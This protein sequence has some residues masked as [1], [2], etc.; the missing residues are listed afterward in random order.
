[1]KILIQDGMRK[2]NRMVAVKWCL[3][4]RRSCCCSLSL[5]FSVTRASEYVARPAGWE[6]R[7]LGPWLGGKMSCEGTDTSTG[8]HTFCY[9]VSSSVCHC[10]Y[11]SDPHTWVWLCNTFPLLNTKQLNFVAAVSSH[12]EGL[13]ISTTLCALVVYPL[14]HTL[15]HLRGVHSTHNWRE[16]WTVWETKD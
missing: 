5:P 9:S 11:Y 16:R 1:M 14:S 7:D 3:L 13:W 8:K 6:W 2:L 12:K 15:K 10:E 4:D